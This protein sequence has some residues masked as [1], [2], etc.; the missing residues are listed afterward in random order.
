MFC[1]K[2]TDGNIQARTV[3]GNFSDK[4]T[5]LPLVPH[6]TLSSEKMQLKHRNAKKPHVA[7]AN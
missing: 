1:L 6:Q 2:K 5:W 3:S 4:K 7:E